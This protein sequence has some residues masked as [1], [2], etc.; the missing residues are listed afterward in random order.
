MYSRDISVF[1]RVSVR[2]HI[3]LCEGLCMW[4]SYGLSLVVSVCMFHYVTVLA[5]VR[6]GCQWV[7]LH[8]CM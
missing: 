8:G 5:S 6:G 3:S 7:W 4:V 1:V 2:S